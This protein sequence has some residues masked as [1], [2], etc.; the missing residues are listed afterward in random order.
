[1]AINSGAASIARPAGG[2]V[3][4][5]GVPFATVGLVAA[6]LLTYVSGSFLLA[7]AF[8]I[9]RYVQIIL[10][11]PLATVALRYL[12]ARPGRLFEPLLCFVIL[13]TVNEIALRGQWVYV[14][15]NLGTLLALIAIFAAP[16]ESV[17]TGAKVVVRLAG[18]LA[19]MALVQWFVLFFAPELEGY[20][21]VASDDGVIQNTVKHPIALLGM[22]GELQFSFLGH[23][24]ARL[25]SFAMEPS[26]N[27]VYFL[28]PAS[29]AFLLNTVSSR[30]LGTLMLSFCVLSFSGSVYL[31]L[32]FSAVWWLLLWVFS[33]RF[34]MLYGT[35]LALVAYLFVLQSVGFEPLLEGIAYLAQYGDFLAKNAS[36]TDRGISA[37]ANTATALTS[38]LGS[39]VRSD[40]AG[41]WFVNAALEAGWLGVVVLL[42]FLRKLG[43]QLELLKK[44]CG[45]LSA[46]RLGTLLLLGAISVVV[47]FNDY[48]M[49]SYA[50]LVLL[51]FIYRTIQ[52]QNELTGS[53]EATSATSRRS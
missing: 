32:V 9:K 18:V 41:P 12:I 10:I 4:A 35:V 23:D 7:E 26:L 8:G 17:A 25:Q 30:I 52:V 53:S 31:A 34:A 6:A 51:G 11:L 22:F 45:P 50:G 47:V 21:L 15:D 46:G 48:Q 33:I 38:P 36:V 1:M 5:F 2:V 43:G 3:P 16:P 14:L 24:V 42:L 20:S 28:L 44:R 39:T 29:L 27:V 13:K 19:V 37:L 40:L 49:S